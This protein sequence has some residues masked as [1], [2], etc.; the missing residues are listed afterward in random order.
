MNARYFPTLLTILL[1]LFLTP[2]FGQYIL[3]GSAQKVSCNCYTLTEERLNESGSVWNSNKISLTQ[4]FDYWFNVYLGGFDAN[5]ADGIVFMLQPISTSI[6]SNGAGMGFAG[7]VPSVGV[8]L[9][10]W[11]NFDLNDPDYDHIS[12]QLNGNINHATDLAGPVAASVTSNNIEDGRWHRLRIT[13]DAASKT[14]STYFD[15]ELRLQKTVDLVATVFNNDPAVYWGFTGATGGS[16]NLQ[17]FCT[18]LDPVITTSTNVNA[19]CEGAPLQFLDAS[20]SFA[21]ITN[22]TWTFGDGTTS[23]EKEPQHIYASSGSYPVTLRIKGQDGCERDSTFSVTVGSVPNGVLTVRDTCTGFLPDVALAENNTAISYHWMLDGTP[24]STEKVPQL[25]QLQ[26]GNHTIS[27]E[28]SSDFSCGQ[29]VLLSE[30]FVIQ[31]APQLQAVVEDGCVRESLL[32]QGTQVDTETT[33]ARWHWNFGDGTNGIGQ[34]LS[35]AYNTAG[36]YTVELWAEGT[37]GC[38]SDAIRLPLTVNEAKAFAGNDTSVIKGLPF[39]LTGTG[40]GNFLWT[41]ATGLSDPTA[42]SPVATLEADQQYILTTTTAEGC[43]A[44]DTVLIKTFV[45][46]AIYVPSAFTPNGDGKNDVLRPVYIGIKEVKQFS[47]FNRWGQKVFGT[48]DSGAGWQGKGFQP[49]S[50][51]WVVEAVDATGKPMVKKG[52]VILIR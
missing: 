1:F 11:Q 9:D 32:F 48:K 30:D 37:N 45:G 22:Y 3:N 46:P 29:P 4:S 42:V 8:A 33:I 44:R 51:V 50:Y 19:V 6:G 43:T 26:A 17:Q 41:P 12:I 10:T 14:L 28:L 27:V 52:T 16:V 31:P 18:A 39:Q 5:G 13:W 7:V 25:P 21:P 24:I 40:V 49:D 36:Q 23:S 35:H 34:N 38:Q 2:A 47:V 20:Q 15:N